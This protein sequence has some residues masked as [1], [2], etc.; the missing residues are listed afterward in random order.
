MTNYDDKS[1]ETKQNPTYHLVHVENPGGNITQV[2]FNGKNYDEWSRSFKLA[3]LA[4][5]K[6]GY[7]DGTI[8]KP[9]TAAADFESWRSINALVTAWIYESLE[10]SLCKA[11]SCRPEAKQIWTDIKNRFC[12]GN[13]ARVYR[14]EADLMACRQGPIESLL[15][16][17]G[18][19]TTIWNELLE[20]NPLPDCSCSA[21]PCDWVAKLDPRR[22]KKWV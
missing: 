8:P 4:K 3:L 12:Q 21:C 2:A 14:L 1:L 11:I 13:D 7:I 16:Y 15:D 6:L 18:R 10:S 5:G 20:Y 9:S 17:Y 19:I 22:E